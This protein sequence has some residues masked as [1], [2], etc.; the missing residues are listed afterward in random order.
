MDHPVGHP[1]VEYAVE[2]A[3]D[4][5]VWNALAGPHAHFSVGH[6]RARHYLRDVAPFSAIAEATEAAYADLGASLPAGSEARL[7]RTAAEPLPEGWVQVEEYPILQ[8]VAAQPGSEP[9]EGAPDDMPRH[10]GPLGAVDVRPLGSA[11]A[12]AMLELVAIAQPG[13]FAGRTVELGGYIGVREGGRLVA[14]AG[15]RMRVSGHSEISAI[16]TH[17][18]ARGRG[19]GELLTRRLM[20]ET[21]ARGEQPF[22]HV[23]LDNPGAIALYHRLGF[24]VRREM[25]VMWRRPAD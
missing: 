25:R 9:S 15:H 7:F 17:P 11:D 1:A 18:E 14:M 22:L 10:R 13:P 20:N 12:A 8:M 23:R 3:L 16:C 21:F 2:H 6:G 5:P 19:L 4:N 24:K